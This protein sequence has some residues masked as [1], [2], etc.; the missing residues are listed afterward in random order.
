MLA[1]LKSFSTWLT[2]FLKSRFTSVD[3][4]TLILVFLLILAILFADS[5]L[6]FVKKILH[7]LVEV[8]E[9]IMEHLL[10]SAFQITPR[11]AEMIVFWIDVLLIAAFLWYFLRKVCLWT[12]ETCTAN[13]DK[14]HSKTQKDKMI[15]SLWLTVLFIALLKIMFI[16]FA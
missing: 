12:L 7:I 3:K 1:P 8:I 14:W 16:A 11:Q 13:I 10:I 4:K 9:S 5:L 2:E 15:T 6:P